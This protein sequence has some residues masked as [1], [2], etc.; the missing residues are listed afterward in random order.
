MISFSYQKYKEYAYSEQTTLK[1]PANST[2]V[3][4]QISIYTLFKP[5]CVGLILKYNVMDAY[6]FI[7]S[8]SRRM[9]RRPTRHCSM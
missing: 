6:Y 9:L 3:L 5:P 7:E 1:D 4:Q 2:P 8:A